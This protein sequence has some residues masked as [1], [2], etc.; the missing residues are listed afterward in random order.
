MKENIPSA[1]QEPP[2]EHYLDVTGEVCPMTFVRTKLL[3][4]KMSSG[5]TAVVCLNSGEP[6]ENVPRAVREHGHSVLALTPVDPARPDGPHRLRLR[7]N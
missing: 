1:Q 6:L 3:I 5:E 2:A 7:K 4:E